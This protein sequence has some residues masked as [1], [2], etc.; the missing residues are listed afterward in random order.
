M[1]KYQVGDMFVATITEVDEQ[2][3][4]IAYTLNDSLIAV[5]SQLN[6]MEMFESQPFTADDNANKQ[7]Y[8]PEDLLFRIEKLSNLLQVTIEK[9]IQ[10]RKS[11]D[12]GVPS[13]D[14]QIEEL[15]L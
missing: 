7:V 15:S 1:T 12:V 14:T 8:T 4:G 2:G 13:I 10:I 11:L 9:Y 5:E 3:M 6:R